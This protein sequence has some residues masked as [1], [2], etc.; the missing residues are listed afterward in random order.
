MARLIYLESWWRYLLLLAGY[1][2]KG[3]GGLAMLVGA[4][5][6]GYL[7]V[8]MALCLWVLVEEC[9]VASADSCSGGLPAAC[10]RVL[11]AVYPASRVLGV[12]VMAVLLEG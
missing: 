7:V 11:F 1:G 2:L 9:F 10:Y 4:C 8:S 6:V 3:A 5:F 12:A